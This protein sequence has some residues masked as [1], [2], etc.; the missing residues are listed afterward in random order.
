MVYVIL[1]V[2]IGAIALMAITLFPA[3]GVLI[4]TMQIILQVLCVVGCFLE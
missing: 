2:L 4:I 3:Y 1:I